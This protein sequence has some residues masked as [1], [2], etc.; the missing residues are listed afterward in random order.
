MSD[1]VNIGTFPD[2]PSADDANVA[3]LKINEEF[4]RIAT[5]PYEL[6]TASA[7][8]LGGIKVGTGLNILDGTLSTNITDISGNAATATKL[9]EDV[10]IN[11]ESFDGSTAITITA[12]PPNN[13]VL[14]ITQGGTGAT[15][16]ANARTSL[17]VYSKSEVDT[18]TAQAIAQATAQATTSVRGTVSLATNAE[19]LAGTDATKAVTPAAFLSSLRKL[20][21]VVGMMPHV[22]TAQRAFNTMYYN[23]RDVPMRVHVGFRMPAGAN[24]NIEVDG[25]VQGFVTKLAAGGEEF[26]SLIGFVDPQKSYRFNIVGGIP[27]IQ[28]CVE[29]YVE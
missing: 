13:Y 20:V 22:V 28:L 19:T 8:T 17:S 18:N 11:G 3:F 14:P 26:Y 27:F 25:T 23:T 7:T 16:A 10:T 12:E 6:P 15:T 5:S 29:Y 21:N 2:D 9:K 24:A 4:K 1:I